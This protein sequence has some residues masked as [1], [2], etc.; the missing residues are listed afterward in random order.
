MPESPPSFPIPTFLLLAATAAVLPGAERVQ[1]IPLEGPLS[2]V[3]PAAGVLPEEPA[4]IVAEIEVPPG[5]PLD[6]GVGAFFADRDGTWF[7]RTRPGTLAPGRHRVAFDFGPGA[8]VGGEHHR[9]DWNAAIR[10]TMHR[11]GLFLWTTSAKDATVVVK[12]LRVLADDGGPGTARRLL[13]LEIG[14]FD[15]D[16]RAAV[17]ATGARW[18]LRCRPDPMPANPFDPEAFEL[19]A[20][21]TTPDGRRESV[22]AFYDRP[23]R[24]VDGG[25]RERARLDGPGRFAVRYRPRLPGTHRVVLR[26]RWDPGEEV[27]DSAPGGADLRVR[28]PDLVARG[29]PWDDFVR[30]DER[31][32]R[33]FT[34]GDGDERAFYWPVGL[35]VRSVNDPRGK[36]CTGSSLTPARGTHAYRAYLER[37]AAAGANAAEI[38]MSSWNLALEWR[39]DWPEFRGLGR[40]NLANAERLDRILDL[41]WELGI[42]INLVITNHGMASDHVDREWHNNPYNAALGGPLREPEEMFSAP[43]AM[44]G[45][46]RLRRYVA[47]RWADHPAVLGWK[48]WTEVNLTAGER[49]AVV[50]WHRAATAAWDRIDIYDHP[51]T[52]HWSSDYRA[53]DRDVVVLPDLDYVCIDAYHGGRD[54]GMLA[55][56]LWDSTN[57]PGMGLHRLE[58]RYPDREDGLLKPIWVT[59]FGGNWN[60]AP[61][62]QLLAEHV[63]APWVALVSGHG[64]SPLLW[65]FEWVDQNDLWVP[66]RAIGRFVADEDLRS[67]KDRPSRSAR[68]PVRGGPLWSAAWARPGR[69]LGYVLERSWGA[70]GHASGWIEGSEIVISTDDDLAGG[71]MAL[72]WWDPDQGVIVGGREFVHPGGELV[73]PAPRFRRHLAFKLWRRE[74]GAAA[75]RP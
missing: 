20:E 46:A 32:P 7:Q 31:D 3:V 74:T 17:V 14:G 30:R 15:A 16:H 29:D 38:W 42:R 63:S 27:W 50:E 57:D 59:E 55:Q 41:A 5:A 10:R 25:D 8:K 69:V 71:P 6:L 45:R 24:L 70:H 33:F 1:R 60:A 21:I 65:W 47:A 12:G 28:L 19:F 51:T 58:A 43:A 56:L 49:D 40:Y 35:N 11:G 2:T 72:E 13:D 52:T 68:L 37:L 18:E 23:I 62:P 64:G 54:G 9:G 66:Y 39:E 22:P 26:A 75:G 53:P 4:R 44:R 61:E 73:L 34:R 36:K 48:L 67:R